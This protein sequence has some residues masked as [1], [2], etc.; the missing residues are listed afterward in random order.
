MDSRKVKEYFVIGATNRV[1]LLDSALTRPGRID[2]NIYFGNPDSETREAIINIHSQGKPMDLLINR[3]DLV[4]TG[5]FSGAQI[6]NLLNEAMLKALRDDREIIKPED[7][8]YVL[9]RIYAGWQTKESKFSDDIIERIV[10]HEMGH[11]IVG[12]LS[13][14]H[15]RLSK[16]VLNLWS[17]KVLV[18]LFSNKLTKIQI[19]IQ[20]WVV[21]TFDGII[22]WPHCGRSILRV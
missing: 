18:I 3:E 13:H 4:K 21:Y 17:R 11:A 22:K 9:N 20:K 19:F 10:I 1:D 5:G 16:I 6:E 15:S 12:L 14:E 8:E 2:K 7:L